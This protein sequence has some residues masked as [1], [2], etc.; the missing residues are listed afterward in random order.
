METVTSQI[1]E[2]IQIPNFDVFFPNIQFSGLLPFEQFKKGMLDP[3][4]KY[5]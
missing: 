1:F 5:E 4:P 3:R 2:Q